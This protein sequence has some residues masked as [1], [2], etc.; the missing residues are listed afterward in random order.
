MTPSNPAR[1]RLSRRPFNSRRRP[2]GYPAKKVKPCRHPRLPKTDVQQPN[3]NNE[4][5][6]YNDHE[7]RE[8]E[9]DAMQTSRPEPFITLSLVSYGATPLLNMTCGGFLLCELRPHQIAARDAFVRCYLEALPRAS[10]WAALPVKSL[11]DFENGGGTAEVEAEAAFLERSLRAMMGHLDEYFFFGTLTRPLK[12]K[13]KP[14]MV[15]H[16]GFDQLRSEVGLQLYGDSTTFHHVIGSEY[17]RIRI[18]SRL[19][20]DYPWDPNGMVPER[21]SFTHIVGTLVHEMVHSYLRLFICKGL[22]CRRDLV[23][24]IGLTGH[25]WTFIKLYSF[26]LGEIWKWHPALATLSIEE[27]IPGTSI[28]MKN[29]AVEAE[30]RM[31]LKAEGRDRD[32][33]PLRS[34]SPRNIVCLTVEGGLIEGMYTMRITYRRPG[35]KIPSQEEGDDDDD[36]DDD[37]E[38]DDDG[39]DGDDYY[40][41]EDHDDC[42]MDDA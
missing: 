33:L 17:S 26:V 32:F 5:E 22:Q 8:G 27:C 9:D 10:A 7:D 21:V 15:L 16:T 23:N 1:R 3:D 14:L 13:V 28:V 38:G 20:R 12:G 42:N 19:S 11:R 24:T 41:D 36:D 6:D 18:W 25:S 2:S 4:D 34:D 31:K 30:A 37:D 35:S 39:D 40:D 29:I